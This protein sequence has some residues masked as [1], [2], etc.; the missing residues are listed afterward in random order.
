MQGVERSET[1]V[2]GIDVSIAD[3]ND[4]VLFVVDEANND[5][6]L[7]LTSAQGS[8]RRVVLVRAGVGA[9]SRITEKDR[10]AFEL[11]NA[12]P[13]TGW[14]NGVLNGPGK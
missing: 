7:Y 10:K 1:K 9:V 5:Q 8:L 4:V 11:K 6:T 12:R 13:E 3:K 14:P 2:Q